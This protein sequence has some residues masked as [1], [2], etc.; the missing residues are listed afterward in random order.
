MFVLTPVDGLCCVWLM[1]C[2]LSFAG[3]S[4]RRY[5][6]TPSIEKNWLGFYLKTETES[7]LR[8]IVF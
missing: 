5:G 4:V 3:S 8:N 6:L 7:S 1:Y 2:I